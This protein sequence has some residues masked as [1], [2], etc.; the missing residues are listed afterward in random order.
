MRPRDVRSRGR[1]CPSAPK[2]AGGLGAWGRGSGA[3]RALLLLLLLSLPQAQ[4]EAPDAAGLACQ[5]VLEAE[6][7]RRAE[8]G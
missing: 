4:P 6:R 1:S 5:P 3:A 7:R 8:T 2:A